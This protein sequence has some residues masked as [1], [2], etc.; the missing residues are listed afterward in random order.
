MLAP[1]P[2]TLLHVWSPPPAVL[3]DSFG[4]RDNARTATVPDVEKFDLDRAAEI[5]QQG[6]ELAK[7]MG[8]EVDTR[9]ERAETSLSQTI[10]DTADALEADLIVVGTRGHTAVESQLLGSVS[11]SVIH[12][13]KRPT[14]VVPS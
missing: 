7:Q 2:V 5:A 10:L 14:L 1:Q 12:Q 11:T 8:L 3:S 4:T 6:A 13:S 9:V